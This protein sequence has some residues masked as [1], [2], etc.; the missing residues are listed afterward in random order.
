[1]QESIVA[2]DIGKLPDNNVVEALQHVSGVSIVR[3]S[4]EPSTVLI[5]GLPDVV[6]TLNGRQIFPSS[7]RPVPLPDFPAQLLARVDGKKSR[8]A[9]AIEGGGAGW[10]DV[11]LHRP[12]DFGGLQIA[13]GVKAVYGTLTKKW[14]PNATILASDRWD[15]GI[16]EIGALINVSYQQ[17]EL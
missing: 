11:T 6:T 4:V 15:T 10:I 2:E 5:R 8:T 14:A 13:G 3:D 9:D 12:F 1:L 16:G 7:R 17:R